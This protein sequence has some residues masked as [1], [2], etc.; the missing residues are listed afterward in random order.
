MLRASHSGTVTAAR[1]KKAG[2][3]E[4]A[5]VRPRN[6]GDQ[7]WYLTVAFTVRPGSL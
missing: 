5:Q 7:N 1:A 2:S 3:E 6:P 4:P